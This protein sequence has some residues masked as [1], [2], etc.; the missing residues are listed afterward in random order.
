MSRK[1]ELQRTWSTPG[2]FGLVALVAGLVFWFWRKNV[3]PARPSRWFSWKELD[4]GGTAG[5]AIR[6]N[7]MRLGAQLDKAREAIGR[8][9]VARAYVLGA[10]HDAAA[11]AAGLAVDLTS[12]EH[13]PAD[14]F[15]LMEGLQAQGKLARGVLT[16]HPAFVHYTL[17]G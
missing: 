12:K 2:L 10:D 8:L 7:L 3:K 1:P 14:L 6:K 15:D 16:L 5:P 9:D 13:D 11:H 4:P 17:E